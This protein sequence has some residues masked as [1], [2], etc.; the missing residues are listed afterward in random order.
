MV[1]IFEKKLERND[2][3]HRMRLPSDSNLE[4]LPSAAATLDVKDQ[5]NNTWNFN[6]SKSAAK[7]YL[8]GKGWNDFLKSQDIIAGN[9]ISLYKTDDFYTIKVKK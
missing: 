4:E 8:G 9:K 1:M 5:D 2:I 3:E 7:S 6:Y